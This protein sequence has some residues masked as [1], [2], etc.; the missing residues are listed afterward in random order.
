MFCASSTT[1]D[2]RERHYRID[3]FVPSPTAPTIFIAGR[4]IPD[5]SVINRCTAI[6]YTDSAREKWVDRQSHSIECVG[7]PGFPGSNLPRVAGLIRFD[8]RRDDSRPITYVHGNALDP[9]GD[10]KRLVCQLV[11][12]R[13][14]K[15]G[16]GIARRAAEKFPQAEKEFA[17][18]IAAL[19]NKDRLGCVHFSSETDG[20]VLASL[21]AQEGFGKSEFPRI[22]YG[23]L[24]QCLNSTASYSQENGFTVH[25][26]RIGTGAA[27]GT[28]E[29]VEE[30]IDECMV[31]NGISV[32]VYDLPPKRK[33]LRLF[34]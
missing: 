27:G 9:K 14:R 23:A 34:D 29:V 21:I 15:W 19:P 22:R 33:Q 30:I 6:G 4:R 26:P 10:G 16:G 7:I 32:T 2:H 24:E 12:D 5:Q 3:Y 28:W 13:A 18:W 20:I 8:S 17:N 25:M 31:A 11:N 1:Q